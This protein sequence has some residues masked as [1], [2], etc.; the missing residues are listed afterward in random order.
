[1][2]CKVTCKSTCDT[3][4]Y[5][6]LEVT[7]DQGSAHRRK[8][9]RL[10]PAVVPAHGLGQ[11]S[12]GSAGLVDER[13]RRTGPRGSARLVVPAQDDG[14]SARGRSQGAGDGPV[15]LHRSSARH[16]LQRDPRQGRTWVREEGQEP[17]LARLR[18]STWVRSGPSLKSPP[19]CESL[20]RGST[21]AQ[22][23]GSFHACA[24]EPFCGSSPTPSAPT[25]G[26]RDTRTRTQ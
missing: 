4:C 8:G 25:L 11:A 14:R 5:T 21:T 22:R 12:G 10:L 13:I 17:P 7:D 20:A 24:S 1:M 3:V 2:Y 16:P 18:S 6:R 9:D 15:R 19:T 23:P 26:A